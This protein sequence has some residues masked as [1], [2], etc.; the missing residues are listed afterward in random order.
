[1]DADGKPTSD[2]KEALKGAMLPFGGPKGY[3]IGFII[4][5]LSC[6][7]SGA[8]NSREVNNFWK[9]FENPQNLGYF[10][11]AFD[12]EKF[13]PME[14]FKERMD[15][16]L[17][18]IKSCPPAPGFLEVFIPGEIEHRSTTKKLAEGIELGEGVVTE[19]KSLGEEY[20]VIWPF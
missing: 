11:G 2:P 4:E 9:D 5:I 13:L 14:I 12:I 10:M 8:F 20:R 16:I 19:L 17:D 7:L 1:V 18:D 3:A 6:I 15:K